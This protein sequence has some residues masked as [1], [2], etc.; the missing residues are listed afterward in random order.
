MSVGATSLQLLELFER[1]TGEPYSEPGSRLSSRLSSISTV[2]TNLLKGGALAEPLVRTPTRSVARWNRYPRVPGDS[3]AWRRRVEA[4]EAHSVPAGNTVQ[5]MAEADANLARWLRMHRYLQ[6]VEVTK[7]ES[8]MALLLLWEVDHRRDFPMMGNDDNKLR[9]FTR[10][11]KRRVAEDPELSG[12]LESKVMQQ[13]L[14]PGL[15]DTHH[16]RWS[17]R[18]CA[19]AAGEPQGWYTEFTG[20]WQAYLVT[21]SRPHQQSM[22]AA[23]SS[24]S[25]GAAGEPEQAGGPPDA[26]TRAMAPRKK[27]RA[28]NPAVPQDAAAPDRRPEEVAAVEPAPK[29]SRGLRGWLQPRQMGDVDMGDS[30][31]RPV[32]AHPHGRG[33][34]GAPT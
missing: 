17:L 31:P 20:R 1:T 32:P 24:S 26:G 10:R 2:L 25:S 23:N 9:S 11:L 22:A 33:A 6:P 28:D 3:E 7:G 18:V 13:P 29:R 19:P 14:S 34:D 4:E 15:A 21:Q 5:R 12:W 16:E 27:R 8:G 30:G